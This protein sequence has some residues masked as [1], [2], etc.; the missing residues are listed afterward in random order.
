M[1]FKIPTA[2]KEFFLCCLVI[3]AMIW[4]IVDVRLDSV[5]LL[6]GK[7]SSTTTEKKVNGPIVVKT[8]SPEILG[9]YRLTR[10]YNGIVKA[11]RVNELSFVQPGKIEKLLV[12]VGDIVKKDEV[13]SVLES[14]RLTLQKKDLEKR[15][16]EGQLQSAELESKLEDIKL[17]IENH[18]LK[19]PFA[20]MIA[21]RHKNEGEI[22][23]SGMPVVRLVE[24]QKLEAWLSVP[25]VVASEINVGERYQIQVREKL[26]LPGTVRAKLPEIDASSRTRTIIVSISSPA[27]TQILPGDLASIEFKRIVPSKG[28]WLPMTALLRD[29]NG[30][31]A[32]YVVE[33]DEEKRSFV[34]KKNIDVELM[35][36]DRVWVISEFAPTE[37]IISDGTY[38]VVPGQVVQLEA[39]AKTKE[40]VAQVGDGIPQK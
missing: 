8:F 4:F 32:V 11:Q 39:D 1:A 33:Q 6:Q 21:L 38:R 3:A 31:W 19:A 34:S 5:S 37:K 20:G 13:I 12:Q 25:I 22:V 26:S 16:S 30:F 7:D 10:K 35:E 36:N 24:I 40:P 17:Q 2:I 15:I 27:K 23:S 18:T 9:N 29:P 28:F 14:P